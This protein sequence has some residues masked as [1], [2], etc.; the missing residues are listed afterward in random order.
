[1]GD[2]VPDDPAE[3]VFWIATHYPRI[4]KAKTITLDNGIEAGYVALGRDGQTSALV[5]YKS[6]GVVVEVD[7]YAYPGEYTADLD[8]L[9][10]STASGVSYSGTP[11]ALLEELMRAFTEMSG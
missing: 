8:A 1:M 4:G 11:E 5:A 2:N 10:Q 3:W 9:L 7:V 6:G